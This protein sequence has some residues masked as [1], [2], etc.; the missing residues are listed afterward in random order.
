MKTAHFVEVSSIESQLACASNCETCSSGAL[1]DCA[2]CLSGFF[3]HPS[4]NVCEGSCP[5]GYYEDNALSTC[6]ECDPACLT[7][8]A[9]G[10]SSCLSCSAQFYSSG[11]SSCSPCDPLCNACNG[12]GNNA[13]Q[14]CAPTAYSVEN[15]SLSCVAA[16]SDFALNYYLDGSECK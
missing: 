12:P 5:N 7:C 1:Q 2:L 4:T 14:A 16:C 3:A 15:T 10:S 13:C 9:S 11:G 8:S 6:P